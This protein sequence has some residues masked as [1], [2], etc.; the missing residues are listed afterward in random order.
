MTSNA[1]V[2]CY[3]MLSG[4]LSKHGELGKAPRKW[5]FHNAGDSYGPYWTVS[6]GSVCLNLGCGDEQARHM[7]SQDRRSIWPPD[8]LVETRRIPPFKIPSTYTPNLAR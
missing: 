6:L 1:D 8:N 5:G 3:E 2:C 7:S 4:A